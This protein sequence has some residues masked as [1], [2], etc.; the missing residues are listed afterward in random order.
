MRQGPARRWLS[1]LLLLLCVTACDS[2]R[3]EHDARRHACA[4]REEELSPPGWTRT[5]DGDVLVPTVDVDR[6]D[7]TGV[8]DRGL[9][10]H[11]VDDGPEGGDRGYVALEKRRRT[12]RFT[13]GFSHGPEGT[14]TEVEVHYRARRDDS[15][16]HVQVELYDGERP[17]G[18]GMR[19]ALGE[20]WSEH[21]DL[22]TGLSVARASDLRARLHLEATSGRGGLRVKSLW[23]R[24]KATSEA[25]RPT[26]T[27]RVDAFLLKDVSTCFIGRRCES[28]TCRTLSD[29]NGTPRVRFADDGSYRAVPPGDPA[30]ATA[31]V[32]QCVHLRLTEEEVA[33]RRAALERFREDVARWTG[34]ALTLELRIHELGTTELGLSNVFGEPWLAPWDARPALLPHL[35]RETDFVLVTSGVRDAA[36]DLHPELPACGL[37]YGANVGVGGAGYGWVPDTA[38]AFNFQCATPDVYT[39]EWL[40]QLH[41]AVHGLSG[42][43]DAYG[44]TYPACGLGEAETRGWFPDTHDCGKDPDFPAC[45]AES[46]GTSDAVNA[47]VLTAHWPPRGLT[48]LVTNHCRDGR[49]NHGE[50]GVDDGAD[51]P[52]SAG[53]GRLAP[54]IPAPVAPLPPPPP[55]AR[56]TPFRGKSSKRLARHVMKGG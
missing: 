26:G 3:D 30:L 33:A 35:A 25:E 7:V 21:A 51:C 29:S 43:E 24:V 41:Y 5:P 6:D 48:R 8:P 23:L 50:A 56:P 17:L 49:Q 16:G 28:G 32:S 34:G 22:F 54:S 10:T 2:T 14:V 31:E 52:G 12:G 11:N 15:D 1:S 53:S 37:A 40:H 18:R 9:L 39:H 38:A 42:F 13:V 55:V 19:Y 27:R 44:T 47:H 4:H 20:E 46:C 45:G 36:L